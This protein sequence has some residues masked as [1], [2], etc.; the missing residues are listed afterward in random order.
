MKKE[1]RE[2][3]A[4]LETAQN[5]AKD[6]MTKDDVTVEEINA[7]TEEIKAIKAKIAALQEI[8]NEPEGG[9]PM[10]VKDEIDPK[11]A[12]LNALRGTASKEELAILNEGTSPTGLQKD[13]APADGGY[14]VP[15]EYDAKIREYMR[16]YKS[17]KELVGYHKTVVT[18]GT[19]I[20][21][22]LSTITPLADMSELTDLTEQQPKFKNLTYAVKDYGALL[23]ISN[24]LLQ[25]EQGGLME[26]IGRWFA[27]KDV[28]TVNSKIFAALIA[29]KTSAEAIADWKV[30]K[31]QINTGLDPMVAANAVIITNQDGF[32]ELD[33]ALDGVGRAVLQPDPVNPTV[34][35]FMGLPVH[36]FSNAELATTGT[37]T[38]KAPIFVGA[39]TE[40]V[41]FIDRGVF[42]M[43][44]SKEFGF[45][46]NATYIRCIDRF[47]VVVADADAY[48]YGQITLTAA[49]Q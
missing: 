49:A 20:Y 14:I 16:E 11:K 18:A 31:K 36:V 21:E 39:M 28:R 48:I 41:K 29:G 2:L 38:K 7:A 45:G 42:E 35:R 34:K 43:A 4:R 47:D 26:Y 46:K 12:F 27:K 33:A 32:N 30:L 19:L 10:P 23:P 22:D 25:D 3:F 40:A 5:N 24:T 13:G 17:A 44:S 1:L 37:T 15:E 9:E 8:E 6:I